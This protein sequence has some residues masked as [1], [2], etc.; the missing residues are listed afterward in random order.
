VSRSVLLTFNCNV[1]REPFNG[2]SHALLNVIGEVEQ[3]DLLAPP[4]LPYLTGHGVRPSAGYL[5]SES[6]YRLLSQARITAGRAGLSSMQPTHVE[7]DYDLFFF[8]RQFP[9]ELA[10]LKRMQGWR[11][12][13]KLAACYIMKT[14]S[15]SL[16]EVQANLKMLDDFDRGI[17]PERPKRPRSAALHQ[18]ADRPPR[19]CGRLP[20]RRAPAELTAAHDRRLQL[21]P[22]LAQCARGVDADVAGQWRFPLRV[23]QPQRPQRGRLG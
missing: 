9:H 16:H 23:R 5:P 14:W 20:A 4:G 15:S 3:A 12:R 7:Q 8:V 13:S 2:Q 11:K 6:F 21:R 1:W 10:A 17:R 22:L 18:R 19:S